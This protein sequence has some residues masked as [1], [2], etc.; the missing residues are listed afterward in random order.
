MVVV[1]I[2]GG[3]RRWWVWRG[4]SPLILAR[5]RF[6]EV[7][8]ERILRGRGHVPRYVPLIGFSCLSKSTN[9]NVDGEALFLFDCTVE[10]TIVGA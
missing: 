9:V 6:S 10:R 5:L 2:V 3:R 7:V 8:L 1:L 4:C